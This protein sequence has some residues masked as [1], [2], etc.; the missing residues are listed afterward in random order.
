MPTNPLERLGITMEQIHA[1]AESDA[2]LNEQAQEMVKYARSIAP[3]DSGKYAAGIKITRKARG[4]KAV[5]SATNWKSHFIE[6]GTGQPGP[7]RPFGVMEKTAQH[8]GGTLN[9]GVEFT[10]DDE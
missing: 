9:G 5:V 1:S 10:G 6:F 2:A 4:G 3:V 7:T 8:F